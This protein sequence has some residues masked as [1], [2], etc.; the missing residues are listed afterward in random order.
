MLEILYHDSLTG[1]VKQSNQDA[2]LVKPFNNGDMLLAMAD[3]M[4]GGVMGA[5]LAKRSMELL[6][7]LFDE[8]TD[9]PL[10]KLK[11]AIF[12]VNDELGVMLDGQK[13]GTTLCMVYYRQGELF[14]I[15]IGDSRVW[16]CRKI[17]IGYLYIICLKL[18][19][20]T[21]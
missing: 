1:R 8:P 19:G 20:H 6:D 5:E 18:A 10:Q 17:C 7:A 2:Y 12:V 16:L 13:G 3:G 9:Y 11:Q 15:N 4:G 14:Y 21:L